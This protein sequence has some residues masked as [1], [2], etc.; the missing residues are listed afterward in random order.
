MLRTIASLGAAGLLCGAAW[1]MPPSGAQDQED[2]WGIVSREAHFAGKDRAAVERGRAAA[3]ALAS[4]GPVIAIAGIV[5]VKAPIAVVASRIEDIEWYKSAPGVLQVHR[6]SDPPAAGDLADLHLD[7]SDLEAM[8]HCRAGAC[9]I[10]LPPGTIEKMADAI[11][12][13]QPDASVRA[14]EFFRAELLDYVTR[15]RAVGNAVLG[16][17]PE[18]PEAGSPAA[19]LQAILSGSACLGEFGPELLAYLR[20]YGGGTMT[21]A[22]D[23]LYWS[24]EKQAGRAVISVTHVT[25]CRPAAA[26][27]AMASKQI[28]ASHYFGGSLG[29]TMLECVAGDESATMMVY[30]NRSWLDVF[31]GFFGGAIR[32]QVSRKAVSGLQKNLERT[33]RRVEQW[34]RRESAG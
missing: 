22:E 3:R 18:G 1:A 2:L 6:F 20:D 14:E 24:R 11:D 15:Y 34:W 9:A 23:F 26:R 33:R 10:K 13:K 32:R 29:L 19:R 17:V 21:G 16:A 4:P 25:A 7:R 31:G 27:V 8:K 30:V 28:Y 5:E 12:W